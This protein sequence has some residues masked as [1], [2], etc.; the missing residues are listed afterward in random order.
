MLL[1]YRLEGD[2]N[3]RPYALLAPRLGGDADYNQAWVASHGGR[4]HIDSEQNAGTTLTA[5]LPCAS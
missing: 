4:L 1:R 5:E 2:P 3:L